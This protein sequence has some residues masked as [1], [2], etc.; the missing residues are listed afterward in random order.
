VRSAVSTFLGHHSGDKLHSTD[1][2]LGWRLP[3]VFALVLDSPA[4]V[5]R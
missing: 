2:A 5:A 3:Y 1:E 4:F